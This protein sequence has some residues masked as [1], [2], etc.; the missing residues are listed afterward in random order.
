MVYV[1]LQF[2]LELPRCNLKLTHKKMEGRK[3]LKKEADP[4]RLVGS[5]FDKQRGL[6]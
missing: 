3:K 1:G 4:S 5:S 6:T 2:S